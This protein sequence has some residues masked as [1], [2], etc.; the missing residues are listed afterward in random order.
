MRVQMVERRPLL[1]LLSHAILLAAIFASCLPM[2]I[3]L[4]AASHPPES[5][6]GGPPPLWFG[7]AGFSAYA[8]VLSGAGTGTG[9]AGLPPFSAALVNSVVMAAAIAALKTLLAL[10][11]AFALVF[12]RA[13]L[14]RLAF[15]IIFAGLML[16]VE[17]RAAPTLEIAARFDL[18]G[19]M[20]GLV[21][22]LVA[23]GAATFLFRQL[24]LT[25][26]R[27][28]LD[29]ARIDGAGPWRFFRDM[30]LPLSRNNLIVV[31]AILF[32][33]GWN[34]YLWPLVVTEGAG[35][36]TAALALGLAAG[37]AAPVPGNTLMA[38]A[39]LVILPPVL[40]VLAMQ[41]LFLKGLNEPES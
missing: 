5:L 9:I 23:A 12:F 13:P 20:P 36:E 8:T 31:F 39:I 1:T 32:I 2:W 28:M 18:I 38:A 10:L 17:I 30:L 25:M 6:L 40:I 35:P 26:P 19:T 27:P 33:H 21:V 37:G 4:V 15:W 16:P 22:P 24:F 29:A 41:R 3:A 7:E 14:G 11:A 34:Q